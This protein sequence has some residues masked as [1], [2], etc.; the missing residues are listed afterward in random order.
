MLG[1]AIEVEYTPSIAVRT[2]HH[3]VA[4]G[5]VNDAVLCLDGHPAQLDVL[6]LC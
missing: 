4:L 3:A 5:D 2:E 6:R 1:V